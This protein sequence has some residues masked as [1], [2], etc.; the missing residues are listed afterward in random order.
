MREMGYRGRRGGYPGYGPFRDLPPW[1]R[2]GWQYGSGARYV[3]DP[4]KCARFPW[5]PRRWWTNPDYGE[6]YPVPPEPSADQEQKFLEEHKEGLE[7][8]LTDVR[9]RLEELRVVKE[10]T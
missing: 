8:E 7:Q 10:T 5:L 2:P 1:R 9:K 3:G 6:T 4:A